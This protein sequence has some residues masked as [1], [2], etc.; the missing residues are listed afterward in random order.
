MNRSNRPR[1]FTLLET[2]VALAVI[3]LALGAAIRASAFGAER[4]RDLQQ[5]TLGGWVASNVVNE[6]LATRAFPD[7][8]ATEGKASMGGFDFT[9]VQEVGPTPNL[10]FRRMEVKVFPAGTPDEVVGRQITY[11]ARVAR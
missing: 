3:S 2:L 4:A 1:G 10:S 11:V 7:M 9:W 5:R 8:G 6:I